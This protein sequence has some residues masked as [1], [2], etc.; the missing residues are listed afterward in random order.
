MMKISAVYDCGV[1][2]IKLFCGKFAE[3]KKN[4]WHIFDI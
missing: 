3:I 1:T 4:M 2:L